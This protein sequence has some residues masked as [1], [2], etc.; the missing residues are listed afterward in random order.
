MVN[1]ESLVTVDYEEQQGTY[2]D[3]SLPNIRGLVSSLL[4]AVSRTVDTEHSRDTLRQY[5]QLPKELVEVVRE[6]L[7][8]LNQISP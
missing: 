2:Y 3:V 6:A 5:L 8:K 4:P 1:C 7:L